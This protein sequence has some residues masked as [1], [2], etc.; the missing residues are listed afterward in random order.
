MEWVHPPLAKLL[1][2]VPMA[3]FGDVPWA[4]RLAPALA[5]ILVA[6]VFFALGRE[7]AGRR[8]ALIASLLLLSDG[9]YLVQSRTAMTNVFALL[10]QLTAALWAARFAGREKSS[11][12]DA[13]GLGL[14]L[15]AAL[16][17]R[18]TSLWMLGLL[19]PACL[20]ARKARGLTAPDLA[21][22]ALAFGALPLLVYVCSY[23]PWMAIAHP[24]DS[25]STA[26]LDLAREQQRMYQYHSTLRASHP[27]SS[28]WWSWPLLKR[29]VWYH[30]SQEPEPPAPARRLRGVV[31]LGNPAVWWASVPV[32][33]V[34]LVLGRRRRQPELALCGWFF[35][36]MWL[37]WSVSPRQLNYS[38][39]LLEAIPWACLA[40]GLLL[41]EVWDGRAREWARGYLFFA[42]LLLLFFLPV[43]T[44][45]P[46]PPSLL[47]ADPLSFFAWLPT[48]V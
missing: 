36:G 23:G 44:A 26:L 21:R 29:P 20:L 37:P 48:W 7:L 17:T 2:A 11:T 40:L 45:W 3:L 19:L 6:P 30:Y 24:T 25:L 10:F 27:Y 35:F 1:I 31:A 46:L 18:W 32:S 22:F 4:F 8:A 14:A 33:L 41:D 42:W 39:Y 16:A 38:H 43:L 5:G 15:G 13:L 28:E 12:L 47:G 34:A 9:V